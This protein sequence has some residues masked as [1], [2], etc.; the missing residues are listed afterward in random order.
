MLV[1]CICLQDSDVIV[2]GVREDNLLHCYDLSSDKLEEVSYVLTQTLSVEH[3]TS[4]HDLTNHAR[5]EL[6]TSMS[7]VMTM[8]A[9]SPCTSPSARTDSI[10]S[11]PLVSVR[12]SWLC[13]CVCVCVCVNLELCLQTEIGSS[14]TP[15]RQE[16]W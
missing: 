15:G 1:L 8:L 12:K 10:Y 2:I 3:Q 9:L 5:L 6:S 14:C 13:V 7:L 4:C 11:S 16:H